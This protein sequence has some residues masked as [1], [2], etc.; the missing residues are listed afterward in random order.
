MILFLLSLSL[1]LILQLFLFI[2]FVCLKCLN[3]IQ[4]PETNHKSKS[5]RVNFYLISDKQSQRYWK[6]SYVFSNTD[7]ILKQL[8]HVI[9]IDLIWKLG[10]GQ[11]LETRKCMGI[12]DWRVGH[13]AKKTGE[14]IIDLQTGTS[15]TTDER[16]T[17]SCKHSH[18]NE[19]SFHHC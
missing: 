8:G 1:L 14:I 10:R 16:K 4:W 11:R 2:F 18:L 15:K 5:I 9:N 19:K 12:S 13:N 3:G 7:I 6:L 17:H